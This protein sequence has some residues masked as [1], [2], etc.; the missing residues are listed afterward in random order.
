MGQEFLQ[1][2]TKNDPI[3]L[4]IQRGDSFKCK[5]ASGEILKIRIQNFDYAD[6]SIISEDGKLLLRDISEIIIYRPTVNVMSKMLMVFGGTWL[7]YGGLTGQLD[8][9]PISGYSDL[10]IGTSSVALGWGLGK[11]FNKRTYKI[12]SRYRLRLIDLRL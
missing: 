7:L 3:S 5:T 1:I 8:K 9:D 2:E 6:T 4:K 11:A 10:A 12:G